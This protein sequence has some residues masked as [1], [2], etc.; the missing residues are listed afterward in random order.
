MT[1]RERSS[2]AR[3]RGV[4]IVSAPSGA[5]KTSLVRALLDRHPELAFS[6]SHTT[7]PCR[8]GEVEGRDYFFVGRETFEQMIAEGRF[9]EHARVFDNW[10]GT[11]R[12]TVDSL[13]T[14]GR[15][16]LLDI[17]WQ[18][19]RQVREALPDAVSIFILPPSLEA[20]AARLRGRGQDSD[21]VIERRMRD[22]VS[23][24]THHDEFDHLV[25][26]DDFELALEDLERILDGHGRPRTSRG[27]DVAK[28][29]K[30]GK[31]ATLGNL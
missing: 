10:Y 1:T 16:V 22:A 13:V 17:D 12:D 26:N 8:P 3:R 2:A 7:R 15:T 6:V 14:E 29:V 5:G 24:M 25:I 30:S 9:L 21:E 19:A 31:T 23:E 18:G 20:L 27:F 11:A 28:L 4:F